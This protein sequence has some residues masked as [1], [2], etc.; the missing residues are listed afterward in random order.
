MVSIRRAEGLFGIPRRRVLAADHARKEATPR[1]WAAGKPGRRQTGPRPRCPPLP[2]QV[3]RHIDQMVVFCSR[4]R[5]RCSS[6]RTPLSGSCVSCSES[7]EPGS[8]IPGE[9]HRLRFSTKTL[10]SGLCFTSS[11]CLSSYLPSLS[12]GEPYLTCLGGDYMGHAL[13]QQH[14]SRQG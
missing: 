12:T 4:T 5:R 9:E 3:F 11:I 10:P 7:R 14:D 8:G 13:A 6:G 2:C 1:D